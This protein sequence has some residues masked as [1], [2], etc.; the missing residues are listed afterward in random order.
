MVIKISHNH[1]GMT[2]LL[3]ETSVKMH[4]VEKGEGTPLS[5][6]FGKRERRK[7]NECIVVENLAENITSITCLAA[8]S[9]EALP[10]DAHVRSHLA[11]SPCG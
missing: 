11:M 5:P 1:D 8:T 2:A 4:G 10:C 7:S 6:M 9:C 3:S